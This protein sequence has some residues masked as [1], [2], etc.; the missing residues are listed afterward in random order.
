MANTTRCFSTLDILKLVET[1]L[2]GRN[3]ESFEDRIILMSMFDDIEL[4]NKC[5]TE[6]CLHSDKPG[7]LC[8]LELASERT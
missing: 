2:N 3:P 4:T 7:H 8:F 5:N 6:S 1:H